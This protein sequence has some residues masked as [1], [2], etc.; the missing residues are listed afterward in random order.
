MAVNWRNVRDLGMVPDT[1]I[2]KREGV[3]R[4]R[5]R[6]IRVKYGIAPYHERDTRPKGTPWKDVMS[7]GFLTDKEIAERKGVT[8]E[9]VTMARGRLSVDSTR[10]KGGD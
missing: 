1:L 3:S 6:Q 2:A 10:K 7:L 5:V 8:R 4:E 9:A